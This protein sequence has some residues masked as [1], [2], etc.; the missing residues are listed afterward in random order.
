MSLP[1]RRVRRAVAHT[2]AVT[3]LAAIVVAAFGVVGWV[4]ELIVVGVIA[5]VVTVVAAYPLSRP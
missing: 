1:A 4:A 3:C 5:I 2:A